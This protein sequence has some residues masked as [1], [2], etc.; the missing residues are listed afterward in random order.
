MNRLESSIFIYYHVKSGGVVYESNRDAQ[1][2]A[3]KELSILCV[4]VKTKG[5]KTIPW[6]L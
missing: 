1:S 5:R 2:D 3:W 6:N 4:D